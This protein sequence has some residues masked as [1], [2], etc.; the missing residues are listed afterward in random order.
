M[1]LTCCEITCKALAEY[2]VRELPLSREGYTH[3]CATHLGGLLYSPASEVVQLLG[4][5]DP[6]PV[7]V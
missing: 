3:A 2:E 1:K 4:P 7:Y 6:T 5:G